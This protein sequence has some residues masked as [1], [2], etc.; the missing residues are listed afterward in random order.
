MANGKG[1]RGGKQPGAG[2]KR[3]SHT[4]RT[5]ATAKRLIAAGGI[6]PLDVMVEAMRF[7]FGQ[8][9]IE[10][11]KGDNANESNLRA[12]LDAAAEKAAQAAPYLH[13]RLQAVENTSNI[14]VTVEEALAAL[15]KRRAA[16]KAREP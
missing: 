8:Y 15:K 3:G 10:A 5:V 12:N 2:R 7:H 16:A 9:K 6:L 1:T 4:I 13:P 11:D 14:Q